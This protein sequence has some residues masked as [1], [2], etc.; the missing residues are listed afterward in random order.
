MKAIKQ[1]ATIISIDHLNKNFEVKTTNS[2]E[3]NYSYSYGYVQLPLPEDKVGDY[4]EVGDVIGFKKLG[5]LYI[6]IVNLSCKILRLAR[7]KREL[8]SILRR[9]DNENHPLKRCIY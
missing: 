8:N 6:E 4:F 7:F 1:R 2:P 5:E 9:L 3:E